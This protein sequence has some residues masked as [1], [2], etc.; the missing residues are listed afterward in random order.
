LSFNDFK[1]FIAKFPEIQNQRYR[2]LIEQKKEGQRRRFYG[3]KSKILYGEDFELFN[4]I[5]KNFS[6]QKLSN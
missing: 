1:N 2:I 5:G 3:R 6:N 4:K